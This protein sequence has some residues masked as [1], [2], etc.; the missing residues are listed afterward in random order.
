[1]IKN[2][3]FDMGKV[4]LDYSEWPV[5]D[6][7]IADEAAKK[8]VCTSVFIS[9]EWIML[10][11]G[12]ISEERALAKMQARLESVEEKRAAAECLAHW[13][14]Y[15]MTPRAKMGAKMKDSKEILFF[16]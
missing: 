13:H 15:N 4:L 12:V 16:R 3:V 9:P 10:D 7:F 5:C 11:M 2:I 14:E 8:A 6:H 1:M